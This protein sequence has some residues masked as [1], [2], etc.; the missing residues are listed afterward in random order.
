MSQKIRPF[1][2]LVL[3][4]SEK[5]GLYFRIYDIAE[6]GA[7]SWF[8]ISDEN[9]LLKYDDRTEELEC[10]VSELI[11]DI[12]DTFGRFKNIFISFDGDIS[13]ADLIEN[14]INQYN[15]AEDDSFRPELNFIETKGNFSL[16]DLIGKVNDLINGAQDKINETRQYF[17]AKALTG[18]IEAVSSK[19]RI[20]SNKVSGNSKLSGGKI[21][22]IKKW[23]QSESSFHQ[24]R[25]FRDVTTIYSEPGEKYVP[26]NDKFSYYASIVSPYV[27]NNDDREKL[28]NY[29]EG[30]IDKCGLFPET[31][32]EAADVSE[33]F[34]KA[35][36][37][38]AAA[39]VTDKAVYFAI[40]EDIKQSD[41]LDYTQTCLQ[42]IN[43]IKNECIS[44]KQKYESG[45]QNANISLNEQMTNI[46]AKFVS[47]TNEQLKGRI[48]A[49]HEE[50]NKKKKYFVGVPKNCISCNSGDEVTKAQLV[51]FVDVIADRVYHMKKS[52]CDS[53]DGLLN[54]M[55][56][57]VHMDIENSLK[58]LLPGHNTQKYSD[59]KYDF[60]D[61]NIRQPIIQLRNL[62]S[63]KSKLKGSILTFNVFS[64]NKQF[65]IEEKK[66]TGTYVI[67]DKD[68][69][70][71]EVYYSCLNVDLCLVSWDAADLTIDRVISY[72]NERQTKEF[73]VI[74]D[75]IVKEFPTVKT[76][77]FMKEM[78]NRIN[79]QAEEK[80]KI[81]ELINHL[82]YCEKE[83][84]R[85][86]T[87]YKN[88]TKEAI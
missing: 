50:L 21:E 78:N 22:E 41:F 72:M 24:T 53:C 2:Y 3:G 45:I 37:V 40:R 66:K 76:A 43:T 60:V 35:V 48:E 71:R 61:S 33:S 68:K 58:T 42:R 49:L 65:D 62:V 30:K 1:F 74:V 15:D 82:N 16:K 54:N 59:S 77:A 47:K 69:F 38:P 4:R 34:E 70:I 18:K 5:G 32:T 85:I 87:K 20:S 29:L 73:P 14:A 86:E 57:D 9:G 64:K 26:T 6:S 31:E 52:F 17:T 84:A 81:N 63:D 80:N 12:S 23:Y 19:K 8:D 39:V 25:F 46:K 79:N 56:A 13:D 67:H 10:Y 28:K 55:N 11:K 83:I 27:K 36:T 44:Q 88:N 7:F 51:S 75:R